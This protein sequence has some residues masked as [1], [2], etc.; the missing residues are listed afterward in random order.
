MKRFKPQMQT[1]FLGALGMCMAA[2]AQTLKVGV[3]LPLTGERADVGKLMQNGLQMAVDKVNQGASKAGPKFELVWADDASDPDT[4]VKALDRFLHD[5]QVVAIAGEIN[6][7]FVMASRPV[8][9]KEGLPYLT[10]GTSPRTTDQAQWIFR[11]GAS[12]AL[13]T[14]LLTKYVVEQLKL[15][16][17][18]VEHDKTGIHNQRAD[19][20]VKALQD[21]YQITAAVNASWSPND[22]DF[23]SQI[24]QLKSKPLQGIIAMGE[25]GEGG[26]FLKQLKAAGVTS[27]VIAHRD[28]GAKT[29]LVESAGGADGALIVT[30]FAPDLQGPAT[31]SWASA[32]L[33]RFGTDPNVIAAQ[34][35]D[36]MLLLAEAV[37]QGGPTRAGIKAGLEKIKGFQGA[38]ADYT[39]DA[40]HNGVHRFFVAKVAGAKL[41]LAATLTE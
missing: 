37:K 8:V 22:R 24:A 28:F 14:G 18:A 17:L 21:K 33:K 23:S 20:I 11:V 29:A 1:F 26:P 31:R 39:F 30:E 36:A 41:T 32:Y 6:S 27:Q 19:A 25:T 40:S 5:P 35:Y 9:E 3:Q 15:K 34:Y 16:D 13:L 10:G 4:G 2:Q 38:M 7:P 12:D